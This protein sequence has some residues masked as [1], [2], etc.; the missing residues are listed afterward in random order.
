MANHQE[1][2]E[3]AAQCATMTEEERE[4]IDILLSLPEF[5]ADL[6]VYGEDQLIA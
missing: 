1:L 3:I 2:P 6:R 5:I 4:V